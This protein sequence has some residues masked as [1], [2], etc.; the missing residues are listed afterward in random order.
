M[1]PY[2]L[3]DVIYVLLQVCTAIVFVAAL[4]AAGKAIFK[5]D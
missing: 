1:N 4:W 2:M 5:K 3:L